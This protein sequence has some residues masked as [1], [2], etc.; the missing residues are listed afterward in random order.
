MSD[1]AVLWTSDEVKAATGGS[2]AGGWCASGV[3]IDSRTLAPGDLFVAIAGVRA[4]GHDYVDHAL[5]NGAAAVVVSRRPAGVAVDAPLVFVGDTLDALRGLASYARDRSRARVIGVTG[6]VGKTGVKEALRTVL[7]A[8][9]ATAANDGSLNNH[10]GLP[11]SLA[12][13]APSVRYGVFEMGMNHPGEILAL[14]RL[15]RPHV[16]V[17][18][19]IAPAHKAFFPS[20]AA[21]ADAKA[22]I[23]AGVEPEGA[24][25]LNRDIPFFAQLAGAATAQG[26]RRIVGF[27]RDSGS[28]VRLLMADVG[29]AGARVQADVAGTAV[30]YRLNLAGSHWVSN[31]LCVLATVHAAGGDVRSAAAALA[32]VRPPR[33]RGERIT[34]PLAGGSVELIDDSY[35]ANPSSMA[36]AIEVLGR[37]RPGSHGRRLA[38]LGDMLELGGDGPALHA[39]VAGP[40]VEWRIDGVFAAGPLMAHLFAALPLMMQGGHAADAEALAPMV[41][42]AIRPGDVLV[43]KGSA[44]SGMATVVRALQALAADPAQSAA[45]GA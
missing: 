11:L 1:R 44:G 31:S 34:I 16:A 33:R 15:A 25:V 36:A 5:A 40:L 6:S 30:D 12:R 32:A 27:G 9:A 7:S 21:I 13:L 39:G 24:A 4:D 14:S 18:T 3:A 45:S 37:A 38:I 28:D 41:C 29:D 17:I 43:V 35:N 2:G 23:F 19:T 10:W 22:E 26:V 20:L 42:K 8:E